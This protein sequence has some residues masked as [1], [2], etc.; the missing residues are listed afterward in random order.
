MISNLGGVKHD[1]GKPPV[2]LL[3]REFLEETARVLEFGAAKYG[4]F[5][6]TKGMKWSRV[7]SALMRHAWA[8][9]SGEDKDPETGITHL[10]HCACCLMFL[11][12]Y[13]KFKKGEDDRYK[14]V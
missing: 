14:P 12:H 1:Q 5:N 3:T 6:W 8:W 9:W 13:E 2:A 10:A 4:T 7:F 11:A